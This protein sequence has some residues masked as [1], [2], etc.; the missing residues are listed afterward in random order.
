VAVDRHQQTVRSSPH[1]SQH[2]IDRHRRYATAQ[3]SDETVDPAGGETPIV[4]QSEMLLMGSFSS[5]LPTL[6]S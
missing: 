5:L 6:N 1:V 3:R 2:P 4:R